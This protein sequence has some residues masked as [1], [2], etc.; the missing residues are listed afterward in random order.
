M[1]KFSLATNLDQNI[2]KHTGIGMD[3][4]PGNKSGGRRDRADT[5]IDNHTNTRNET[6]I[7]WYIEHSCLFWLFIHLTVCCFYRFFFCLRL[8]L[9][10]FLSSFDYSRTS[11][12][13][14]TW[15]TVIE[16]ILVLLWIKSCVEY[17]RSYR[18]SIN[19]CM[20]K[21]Y[22]LRFLPFLDQCGAKRALT[23]KKGVFVETIISINS[24][25]PFSMCV[26]WKRKFCTKRK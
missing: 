9:F 8:F 22:F 26:S 13:V 6:S 16:L 11:M 19:E 10:F 17:F 20:Y 7:H 4:G 5:L 25:P 14:L 15:G 21:V 23:D 18:H 1:A 24:L 3:N 2:H 12:S